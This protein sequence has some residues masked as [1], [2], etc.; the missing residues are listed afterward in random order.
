MRDLEDLLG[1]LPELVDLAPNRLEL[2]GVG[3]LVKLH[4]AFVRQIV[5]DW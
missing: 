4:G 1:A 2:N 3:E 5:E